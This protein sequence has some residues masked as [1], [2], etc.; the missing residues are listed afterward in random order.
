MYIDRF[1]NSKYVA[2]L[3]YCIK[4][5]KD[6]SVIVD[7]KYGIRNKTLI[8]YRVSKKA[9]SKATNLRGFLLNL[10]K[11]NKII[12]NTDYSIYLYKKK[13]DKKYN[14]YVSKLN[15]RFR[16]LKY[17]QYIKSKLLNILR[18][19][20][21]KFKEEKDRYLLTKLR[22]YYL[23]NASTYLHKFFKKNKMLRLIVQKLLHNQVFNNTRLLNA[24]LSLEL[25]P[26]FLKRFKSH[27]LVDMKDVIKKKFNFN[28]F[29]LNII[30]IVFP[31]ILKIV[32]VIFKLSRFNKVNRFFNALYLNAI[33]KLRSFLILDFKF[34]YLKN[35]KNYMSNLCNINYIRVSFKLVILKT[36]N[37]RKLRK[38][39]R[40]Y[41][42]F[43]RMNFFLFFNLVFTKL[44]IF[45]FL[46]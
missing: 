44:V 26:L 4:I 5:N 34:K 10:H 13:F 2:L 8:L 24:F 23:I 25:H 16:S 32:K 1:I 42:K 33:N 28:N 7:F 27:F 35:F 39:R 12:S 38:V 41:R 30:N 17:K 43:K 14:L 15:K 22:S 3:R 20:C 19:K 29:N 46:Y 31:K 21:A 45:L 40:Y 9:D 6:N 36:I 37:R 11:K 18:L